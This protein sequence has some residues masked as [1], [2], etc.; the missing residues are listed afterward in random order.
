MSPHCS[1][2]QVDTEATRSALADDDLEG[3]IGEQECRH[4][5]HVQA[6]VEVRELSLEFHDEGVER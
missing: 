5:R 4:R 3:F 1:F 2:G 6:Q